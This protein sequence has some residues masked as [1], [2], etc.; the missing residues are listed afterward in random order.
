[1]KRTQ[2]L[3]WRA[4]NQFKLHIDGNDFYPAM[5]A[6]IDN[7][8][9]YILLEQYSIKS[10][11]VFDELATHLINAVQHKVA[12][13]VMADDYGSQELLLADRDRLHKENIQLIFFN[14]LTW[15]SVYRSLRRNHRKLLVIDGGIAFVG[16][17]GIDDHNLQ[18]HKDTP[19]WHD[20]MIRITGEV[21][22]DWRNSFCNNWQE[23]TGQSLILPEPETEVSGHQTG[24][25]EL[26]NGR[27]HNN[28]MRSAISRIQKSRQRVWI[29][30]PYFVTTHRLRLMLRRAAH[31][32]VDVRLLLPG[33]ISDHRWIS[34]AARRYY[35]KMLRNGV[36]IFEYQP[37]FI[38]AKL[39]VCDDWVSIGSSNLDRWN[40]RWN[41]DA[42]QA[43]LS[44]TFTQ[45]IVQL[46]ENDFKQSKLITR[47]SW[48]QRPLL[49]RTNEWLSGHYVSLLQW[50]SYVIT[51]L[52]K[53][54]GH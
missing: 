54:S 51:R 22:T 17:A 5:F 46:F 1:M 50:F 26:A 4:Q 9:H 16:G 11:S 39:I 10:G 3:P 49:Q 37:R 48:E 27:L 2:H 38:H 36:K 30:T 19:G 47:K 35:R 41:L 6:A 21:V 29:A 34:Q 40:Q 45:Q 18:Q 52:N 14:P 8:K 15:S 23:T 13:Y 28:I 25:I 12:V 32:D 43:I 44:P 20:V 7:A 31:R 24:R 53:K 33:P 42:N